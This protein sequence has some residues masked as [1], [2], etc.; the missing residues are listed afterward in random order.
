MGDASQLKG[1]FVPVITPFTE[2]G[3]LYSRGFESILDYLCSSGIRGIWLLGSYG[4]FPL[5]SEEE[6]MQ[7]AETA[8]AEAKKLGMTV[9]VNAA[10]LYTDMAVRLA[11]HA[12]N[13]GAHG[14][15]STV[16][17]YYAASHYTRRN[18]LEYFRALANAVRVPVFFYNNAKATGFS[19]DNDF[20]AEML[21]LGITG[22]KS[23]GDYLEM[24]SQINLVKNHCQSAVYLSGTTSVHLQGHILGADGVTSGVALALPG[25]VIRL[26]QALEAGEI[27][28]AVRLQELVLRARNIMGRYAGRALAC[29]DM[30]GHKGVDAGTCRSPWLRIKPGRAREVIEDLSEI[31]EAV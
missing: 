27:K 30:L 19:P 20:F 9:I 16:P 22:F 18:F 15:A 23:K 14:V 3:E 2:Q 13:S 21:D 24:S 25:L 11:R 6:R 10:S 31:R 29:Y 12:E 5:L 26:Q 28:E 17:F 7:A 1:I 8:L 4:A